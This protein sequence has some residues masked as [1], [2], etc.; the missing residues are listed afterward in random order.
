MLI[1][2]CPKCNQQFRLQSKPS[3]MFR[4]PKCKFASPF[5][6]IIDAARKEA[7]DAARPSQTNPGLTTTGNATRAQ[8]AAGNETRVVAGLAGGVKTQFVPGL[9]AKTKLVPELQPQ[10]KAVLRMTFQG[11]VCGDKELPL[12]GTF[13]LG[14]NSS[15]SSATVKL[16]PDKSMSRIHANMRVDAAAK[17]YQ[18]C[19]VKNTNPVFV[20]GTA[21]PVG[22]M[23]NLKVGDKIKMGDTTMTFRLV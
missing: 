3:A 5:D 6:I 19:T 1:I 14:R 12:S 7:E 11:R 15:D 22:K 8:G 23:C 10:K 2:R 9:N 16:T 21:L 20:N 18:I 17:A 4:C 13:T